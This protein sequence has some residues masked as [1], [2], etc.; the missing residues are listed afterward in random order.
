MAYPVA[1][2]L[3]ALLRYLELTLLLISVATLDLARLWTSQG[4]H[5]WRLE[6]DYFVL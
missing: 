3:G 6:L 1:V 2:K 4:L 5:L